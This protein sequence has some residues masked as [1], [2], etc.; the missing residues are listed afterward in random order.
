MIQSPLLA[1]LAWLQ[2]GFGT[3]VDV[4]SST[5][6]AQVKQI[7][8]G[9]VWAVDQLGLAGEGDALISSTPGLDLAIRTADC[10]PI[11][12]AD[13]RTHVVAAIHAGWR[14]TAAKIAVAAMGKMQ[15]L[16]GSEPADLYAAIGPGI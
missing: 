13:S 8:S 11:L 14:G 3:R 1:Q 10:Y 5:N 9:I 2:H 12:L 15:S 7:H 6:S 4:W 16:Y